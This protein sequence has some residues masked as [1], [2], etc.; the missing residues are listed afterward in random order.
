MPSADPASWHVHMDGR[1]E[2][3]CHACDHHRWLV[4]SIPCWACNA[5]QVGDCPHVEHRPCWCV[6]P[7]ECAA[8][9][10]DACDQPV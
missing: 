2:V 9:A 10:A 4:Q 8:C 7:V 6:E 3:F 5:G 1:D